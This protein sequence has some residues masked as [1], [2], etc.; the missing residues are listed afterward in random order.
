MSTKERILAW[1]A[2]NPRRSQKACAEALGID[3]TT[4]SY[5]LNPNTN[6]RVKAKAKAKTTTG[7]AYSIHRGIT[8]EQVRREWETCS[9]VSELARRLGCGIANA[10]RRLK[11][12]GL[13]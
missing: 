8:E 4:V 10:R 3:P 7:N 5:H 12:L 6:A 11:K 13:T 2:A 1:R 9:S